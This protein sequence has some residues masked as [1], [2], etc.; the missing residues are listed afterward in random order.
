[1]PNCPPSIV[2]LLSALDCATLFSEFKKTCFLTVPFYKISCQ[3]H[4][5]F[6][7]DDSA[8]A[9]EAMSVAIEGLGDP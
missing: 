9:E 3:D 7:A 5:K 4:N 6:Q 2:N 8:V 1:M